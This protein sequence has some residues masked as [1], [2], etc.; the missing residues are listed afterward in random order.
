MYHL[1]VSREIFVDIY[2]MLHDVS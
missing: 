2:I 1:K